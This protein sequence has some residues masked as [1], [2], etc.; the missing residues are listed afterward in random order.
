[1]PRCSMGRGQWSDQLGELLVLIFVASDLLGANPCK[2]WN[3]SVFFAQMGLFCQK[4]EKVVF[5][6]IKLV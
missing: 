6:L 3:L 5:E 1:M 2:S 4:S